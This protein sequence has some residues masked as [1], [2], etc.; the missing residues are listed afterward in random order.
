MER[1]SFCRPLSRF[2]HYLSLSALMCVP[3]T[4][5]YFNICTNVASRPEFPRK[6]KN[7]FALVSHPVSVAID[8]YHGRLY[9]GSAAPTHLIQLSYLPG[10]TSLGST[11]LRLNP[12]SFKRKN[13]TLTRSADA[14]SVLRD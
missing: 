1:F 13:S 10:G 9:I 5:N 8:R 12:S 11:V 14:F 2:L 4:S 7:V 3:F 6:E